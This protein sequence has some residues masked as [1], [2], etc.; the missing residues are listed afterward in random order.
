MSGWIVGIVLVLALVIMLVA[1]FYWI[2][3]EYEAHRR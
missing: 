1:F 3:I 2:A